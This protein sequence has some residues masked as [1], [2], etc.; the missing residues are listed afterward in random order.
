[1]TISLGGSSFF[2]PNKDYVDTRE[3]RGGF[4]ASKYGYKSSGLL[5][6]SRSICG[7]PDL[8]FLKAQAEGYPTP[9]R[10][11]QT[12]RSVGSYAQSSKI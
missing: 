6:P 10:S 1:M 9:P 2:N 12:E 8:V 11:P 7:R 5:E 3:K 4:A